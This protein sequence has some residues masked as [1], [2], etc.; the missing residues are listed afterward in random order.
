MADTD[1]TK[2]E[3][4]LD[5]LLLRLEPGA[6]RKLAM[7]VGQSLRRSNAQRIAANKEP[8]GKAMAA[9]RPRTGPD[10]KPVR[11]KR[12]FRR[13]R[14]ARNMRIK[15]TS[16]S[17]ELDF[18]DGNAQR[19]AEVHHDGRTDRV[20]KTRSGR[21]IRARYEARRLLGFGGDDMDAVLAAV[22]QALGGK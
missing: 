3:D 11:R 13:L 1:L 21:T 18:G 2:V 19:I 15:A 8:D 7:K 14:M 4:W 5:G 6:R 17:V 9:R 16:D 12:M 20:G 10:G 22:T